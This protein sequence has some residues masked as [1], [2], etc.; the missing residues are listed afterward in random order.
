M[1]GCVSVCRSVQ[2]SEPTGPTE[3]KFGFGEFFINI[4]GRFLN[5]CDIAIFKGCHRTKKS[6]W[7]IFLENGTIN[8]FHFSHVEYTLNNE[9]F[10]I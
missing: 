1:C 2:S 3:M 7:S 6:C 9:H 8:F 4:P 10:G 5:F